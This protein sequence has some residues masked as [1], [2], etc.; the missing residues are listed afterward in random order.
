MQTD[1]IEIDPDE[2]SEDVREDLEDDLDEDIAEQKAKEIRVNSMN[3][4]TPNTISSFETI[5]QTFENITNEFDLDADKKYI[6]AQVKNIEPTDDDKVKFTISRKDKNEDDYIF[7]EKDSTQLANLVEYK[8]VDNV[9]ELCGEK[10]PYK[11]YGYTRTKERYLIP[12]NLSHI[13]QLRYKTHN[14]ILKLNNTVD[15]LTD[16]KQLDEIIIGSIALT[17]ISILFLPISYIPIFIFGCISLLS[18]IL[19]VF[20]IFTDI[21][22]GVLDNNFYKIESE[23]ETH[24]YW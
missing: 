3:N 5:R 21:L 23:S 8:N 18:L 7:L 12:K 11:E 13:S 6:Y 20:Y 16:I 14:L 1:T 4:G 9:S 19:V 2:L 22:V 24:S 15:I 17:T 10:I